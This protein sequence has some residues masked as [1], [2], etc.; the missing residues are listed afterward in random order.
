MNSSSIIPTTLSFLRARAVADVKFGGSECTWWWFPKPR[1]RQFDTCGATEYQ[2]GDDV[3]PCFVASDCANYKP[4]FGQACCVFDRC[5]C[6]S[7]ANIGADRCA[8]FAPE[9]VP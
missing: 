2:Q 5:I 1:T 8:V 7:E 6:E 4:Q 9:A 3:T